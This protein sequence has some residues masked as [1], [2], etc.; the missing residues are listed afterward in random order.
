MHRASSIERLVLELAGEGDPIRIVRHVVERLRE[1]L[2]AGWSLACGR[3]ERGLGGLRLLHDVSDPEAELESLPLDDEPPDGGL[4]VV[5]IERSAGL[6]MWLPQHT[7]ISMAFG[8]P[9]GGSTQGWRETLEV[10][11]RYLCVRLRDLLDLERARLATAALERRIS[12]LSRLFKGVDVTLSSVELTK[13]LRAFMTCVTSGEAI[14][15]SRAFLLLLDEE[16]RQLRGTVAVGPSSGEEARTIW[17]HLEKE[18]ASLEEILHRSIEDPDEEPL[19]DSLASRIRGFSL[20]LDAQKS[21]LVR[22]ATSSGTYNIHIY[23]G[24][25]PEPFAEAFGAREF[26]VIPILGRERTLGVIV[27]DSLYTG[28]RIETDRVYLLSGLANHVGVVIENALMFEDVS[29]RYAELNEVQYVNR[30]L[31]SSVDYVEVLR[32]IAQISASMLQANGSLLFISNGQPPEPRLEMQF[33]S[34]GPA[35]PG[36]AVERCTTLARETLSRSTGVLDVELDASREGAE[37]GVAVSLVSAPM[38]IDKEVVG[39]L[40][41]YRTASGAAE[42]ATRFDRHSR[43]FLSII[44]DQAAIAVL[45]GRHLQTI[46]D[47]QRQIEKLN[48]LLYLNEKL[49]ALG[50]ASSQIA[51]EIRNPLTALGGFAR[52]M[53]RSRRLEASDREAVEVIVRETARLE[54]ILNDQLAFVRSARLQRAPTSL[55]ALVQE[56]RS[57][58]RQQLDGRGVQVQVDLD[59]ELPQVLLD[60]DRMKQVLVNLLMN[61]IAAVDPGGTIRIATRRLDR[62]VE[63]EMANTGPPI[64]PEVETTLFVPFATT[65][66]EGTGL[67]LAVVHQIVTEH[68]GRIRVHSDDPW[69]SVFKIRLPASAPGDTPRE[70]AS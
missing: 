66:Q 34:D 51:H 58:L 17:A 10:V 7:R 41:V 35:L 52:R 33:S 14:G 15:F 48:K 56:S 32:Q 21:I 50:Q 37:L 27:A 44:A 19:P 30:A 68:G 29:R 63:V 13:V 38:S 18:H 8:S 4:C 47:D 40:V 59:P 1:D 43:R 22:A 64:P 39:V 61:A 62:E 67:G 2:G 23:R 54:R 55:N 28:R 9:E 5:C 3:G 24:E 11:G 12:D 16:R 20:S 46:R 69:G 31:L 53:L 36:A 25:A 70:T 45:S 26:V 49:A 42:R 60:A 57:L 65:R 6:C